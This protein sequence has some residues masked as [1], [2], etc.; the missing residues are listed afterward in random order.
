M[1]NDKMKIYKLIGIGLLLFAFDAGANGIIT[2]DKNEMNGE[3]TYRY[4]VMS[5]N[6]S[7]ESLWVRC[8]PNGSLDVRFC[9]TINYGT[10]INCHLSYDYKLDDGPI[11]KMKY[12]AYSTDNNKKNELAFAQKMIKH[13]KVVIQ[14]TP[15]SQTPVFN[16]SNARHLFKKFNHQCA[17]LNDS[18]PIKP[19]APKLTTSSSEH[20]HGGRKHSHSL[21]K[22]GVSHRHGNGELGKKITP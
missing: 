15:A 18:Q 2:I 4:F 21:P 19:S 5:E 13:K 12:D 8:Y 17:V 22:Q 6:V 20:I 16:I 1:A 14:E 9:G 7:D 10:Q 11:E 3:K